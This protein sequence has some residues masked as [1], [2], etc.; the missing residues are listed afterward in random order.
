MLAVLRHLTRR[1]STTRDA[2]RT[3]S[4]TQ[5]FE[6][7]SN[8]TVGKEGRQ[9]RGTS[10]GGDLARTVLPLVSSDSGEEINIFI[11]GLRRVVFSG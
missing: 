7:V 5:D 10:S 3:T 6:V 11:K 9:L 1:E 8:G 2:A 4:Q